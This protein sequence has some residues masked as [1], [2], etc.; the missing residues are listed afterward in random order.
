MQGVC[1][2]DYRGSPYLWFECEFAVDVAEGEGFHP[3]EH[4]LGGSVLAEF[5]Q[6]VDNLSPRPHWY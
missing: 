5:L 2:R 4:P 1:Y 6:G 3:L